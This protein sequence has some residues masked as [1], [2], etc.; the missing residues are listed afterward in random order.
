MRTAFL[1]AENNPG[2]TK[3]VALKNTLVMGRAADCGCVV[4]DA[5]AS[6][7]HVEI[8]LKGDEYRWRDLGS[9]NGTSVNG[10]SMLEGRLNSGDEIQIGES[11][12]RFTVEQTSGEPLKKEEST[13]FRHTI[14]TPDGG[15]EVVESKEDRSEHILKSLYSVINTISAERQTSPLLDSIVQ[16]TATALDARRCAVV[17]AAEGTGELQPCPGH[18]YVHVYEDGEVRHVDLQ[19]IRISQTVA[20][21]VIEQGESVLYQDTGGDDELNAAQSIVSLEL[22]SI[23]CVPLHGQRRILGILYI[24]TNKPGHQFSEDELLLSA[25]IGNSAGLALDNALLQEQ[26]LEQQRIEQELQVAWRIQ[27][28]FLVRDWPNEDG[29][30]Q[31]YGETRPAKTVG[32]DFYDFVQPAPGLAGIL[33]GDVSGKGVPAA[34]A[35]AKLLA[36]FRVNAMSD[37]G[38]AEVLAKLNSNFRWD[39]QRGMFCTMLYALIDLNTGMMRLSN[40]GHH[41]VIIVNEDGVSE[42]GPASGPPIGIMNSAPWTEE[43]AFLNK[44]DLVLLYTDG[45]AEA[46][47]GESSMATVGANQRQSDQGQDYGSTFFPT[48]LNINKHATPEAM[49]TGVNEDVLRFCGDSSPHDDCTLIALR[50]S[51]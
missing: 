8:T 9:T 6:R 32:G 49:V 4:D 13:L 3:R 17:F 10:A 23:I 30:F 35:M 34:L 37:R 41:S 33:I 44:G 18:N 19:G 21:R 36:E 2:G 5:A 43:S 15:F 7:R 47:P 45:I 46:K 24:D 12:F 22:R 31:V 26:L 16:E 39:S 48:Y 25:A 42:L 27:E 29:R 14:V 11:R 20:R 50:Y 28:G 51:G 38:P 40:A 1:T